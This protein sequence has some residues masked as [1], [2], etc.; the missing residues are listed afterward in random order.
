MGGGTGTGSI[1]GTF[2]VSEGIPPCCGHGFIFGENKMKTRRARFEFTAEVFVQNFNLPSDAK[3]HEIR[4]DPARGIFT[5][6]FFSDIVEAVPEGQE[7]LVWMPP[8]RY[9]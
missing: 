5:S 6:Y 8:P 1:Y 7:S 9:S 4:Y 3:V 2:K